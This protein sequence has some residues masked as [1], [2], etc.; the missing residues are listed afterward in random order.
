MKSFSGVFAGLLI[1]LGGV[2]L[3]SGCSKRQ[4][5]SKDGYRQHYVDVTEKYLPKIS[6]TLKNA[7]FA[8][9]NKGPYQ[10]LVIHRMEKGKSSQILLLINKQKDGYEYP[11]KNKIVKTEKGEILFFSV[12]DFN[13]DRADDLILIQSKNG[14]SFASVLF[15]NK[16]GYFYRKIDYFIP[17]ISQGIDRVEVVDLDHDGDADLFFHGKQVLNAEGRPDRTQAQAFINNGEGNFQNLSDLLLPP[18][19][20]GISGATIADY[21]GDGT[22]DIF[23][24]YAKK[25]SRLLFNNSLGK[26]TDITPGYLPAIDDESLH[27]DW[28]DF[29]GDEDND[30]LVVNHRLAPN[31]RAYSG[32]TSYFLENDGKGRF[33][34]RSH[35]MFP[36]APAS[37]VYLLDA[38][39]NGIPDALILSEGKA[40]FFHG[41]GKWKF[42]AETQKRLPRSSWIVEM[43]F[44]DIDDDSYLDIFGI[45]SRT[46]KGKL[47]LNK[48]K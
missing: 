23:L 1:L 35:K 39:G 44:G 7:R 31:G 47:W 32:E 14:R 25:R 5:L 19:P 41:K 16:K 46:G 26:F 18:L 37:R 33:T 34:K 11:E 30:L 3:F 27:V 45:D 4:L 9:L 13:R 15:N 28:A 20:P 29:D 42:S 38:N 12:G 2:I 10:D 22:R 24:I 43:A 17:Q 6:G 36:R 8:Y 40:L 48:F 21:D